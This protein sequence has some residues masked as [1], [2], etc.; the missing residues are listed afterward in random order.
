MSR[1]ILVIAA[2]LA[3]GTIALVVNWLY[4]RSKWYAINSL[5]VSNRQLRRYAIGPFTNT[6]PRQW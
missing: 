1:A 3:P 4:R 6:K 2:L 5:R